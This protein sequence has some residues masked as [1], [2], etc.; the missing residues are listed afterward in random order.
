MTYTVVIEQA[1]APIAVEM[2]QTIL[3][4]AIAQGVPYP[5]G[6]RSG[7]CGACKSRL[8][9]GDVEMSPYSEFALTE[10]EREGGLIL[11]CRSVPW[12]DAEVAWLGEDETV[13]HPN[14]RLTCRVAAL[15]AMTHDIKRVRLE[16]VDGGPFSFSPGQYCS[17]AFDDHAPRDYS[18]ANTPDAESIELHVRHVAGGASS[19]YV[20]HD[21]AVGETVAVEGPFGTSWLREAHRGAIFALAGGSGLAPIKA[22]VE[23][24]LDLGMAQDIR[25]YFGVRDERDLY[26]EDHFEAL[27]ARHTNLAFIPVLSDP[28]GT[29]ERRTGF[30]HHALAADLADL[31]DFGGLDGCKAYLAGPPPMVEAATALLLERGMRRDDVHADAFY[32]EADKAGLEGKS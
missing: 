11:A 19:A 16:I 17:V 10:D 12:S 14:R 21:L 1:E 29:T 24:A 4:S 32:T 30:V 27:C 5:H 18:M 3:E 23:R 15:D 22:M 20:A 25:L 28:S 13:H 31:G 7:N 9:A 2:G 6:C 26:L 8:I